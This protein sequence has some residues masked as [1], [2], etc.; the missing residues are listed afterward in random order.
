MI[1]FKYKYMSFIICNYKWILFRLPKNIWFYG[2]KKKHII[3]NVLLSIA[4]LFSILFQSI[5]SF[6]HHSIGLAEKNCH[7]SDSKNKK[8]LTHW[9]SIAEK[10]PTCDF[11]FSSFTT[12]PFFMLQFPNKSVATTF[13]SFLSHQHSS[14]FT[15][16]LF[17]LR[18]PPLF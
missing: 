9:H 4:L 14:F 18:A 7:H 17:S 3:T 8:E 6:E 16:S 15:G 1:I 10:C 5:H 11:S 13:Y 12:T 2:M